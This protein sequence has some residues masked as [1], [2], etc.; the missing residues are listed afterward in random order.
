MTISGPGPTP[1]PLD[2]LEAEAFS[3]EETWVVRGYTY[4]QKSTD[5]WDAISGWL[6]DSAATVSTRSRGS[7]SPG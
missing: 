1:A 4:W 3:S 7:Q 2:E 5:M 6:D